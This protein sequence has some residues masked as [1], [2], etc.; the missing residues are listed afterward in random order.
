[1]LINLFR[2]TGA[3]II[4]LSFCLMTFA[5]NSGF[6]PSRMDKSVEACDNFYQYANGTWLKKTEIP[7]AFPSWGSF[8]ILGTRNRELSRDILEAAMKNSSAAKGSTEQLI[9]DY[10]ASCMNT[11]AIEKAGAK[12]LKKYFKEIN[13][14]KDAKGL[15]SEIAVLHRRGIPVLF[16]F[17]ANADQRNSAM[18]I[19]NV[20]Q[21]G[22]GL[23]NRDYYTKDDAKSKELRD[24]YVAH[25]TRMFGLAGD[26]PAQA[27][28]NADS[29][30]RIE[31]RLALASKTP[32]E[33]R[34]PVANFN[35]MSVADA[36]KLMP[37]FA[38]E[39]YAAKLG[40]PQFSEIN[41][42][43][44]DFFKEA[45]KMITEVSLADWKTYLRWNVL[46]NLASRL[47]KS[48]DD[49]DF[50]FY[51]RTLNGTTEQQPRWRRCTRAADGAVGEALGQE[52]VKKNFTADAKRRMDALITN[53]FAAY[54]ERINKADWMTDATRREALTKLDAIQ[55]KIGYPDKLRGYAGLSVDRKSYFEN[56][57]RVNEFVGTRDLRDIGQKVDKTR[58]GMTPPTVNAYYNPSY[59][60]IVFPAGILQPPFFDFKADDALNYGAIGA[61]IGHELTHGFDD[62]GSQFD[63]VGNLKMWWTPEDRKKFEEKA[64]CVA[65]EFSGFEVEKGLFINGKLTLGENLADLGGLT[66]AYDALQKSMQGKSRPA[67][68][69]GFTP[70]QRF[71]LGWAQVWSE[72][73]RPEFARLMVQ[74]NPHSLAQ[75]RVNGP[76]PNLPQFAEAFG[77]KVGDKMVS[78]KQCKVW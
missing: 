22:L 18:N 78:Q 68:I 73:A 76:L 57:I 75:F 26:T 1:M 37:N 55:R 11:D 69:D 2:Q 50:D 62:Q 15:Q 60:E 66:I 4:L 56:T 14:I 72:N 42:S 28:A 36:D 29:V 38:L 5:Q 24:K 71:F 8:D 32:V 33:E 54:R 19:A 27:K 44:P 20:Y 47:P 58:W 34:D 9:G 53:L 49:A 23:P 52:Y 17:Y 40:A 21:G 70:E 64:D 10:Y 16:N 12:P 51:Q 46:N 3:I 39:T 35:K 31:M 48:F 77:C 74:S 30:M 13:S 41:V 63:A 59:N 61:V 7:A 6:D 43:Q 65:T 25:V 67:N 45:G